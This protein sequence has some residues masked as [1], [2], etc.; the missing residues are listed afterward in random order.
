[1]GFSVFSEV[2]LSLLI[3]NTD[4]FLVTFGWIKEKANAKGNGDWHLRK[5]RVCKNSYDEIFIF[6]HL[7]RRFLVPCRI[8]CSCMWREESKHAVGFSFP[9]VAGDTAT[10]C[11]CLFFIADRSVKRSVLVCWLLR[12][13][14]K[15]KEKTADGPF[16]FALFNVLP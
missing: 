13:Q 16:E 5:S 9:R 2:A 14:S 12:R 15:K 8:F 6:R 4:I 10:R 3:F 1:M 7:L 11:S